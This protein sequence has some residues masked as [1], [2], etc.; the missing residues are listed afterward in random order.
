[1]NRIEA[2]YVAPW[3]IVQ[4]CGLAEMKILTVTC[5]ALFGTIIGFA[6]AGF[7]SAAV[8]SAVFGDR[9]GSSSMSGFF[10][11]GPA[12]ALAGALLGA[13]L[14]LRFGGGASQTWG[15]RL[16]VG[17]CL[18]TVL[19]GIVLAIA[20]TPRRGPSYSQ[21]IEFELEYPSAALAGIDIP[22]ANAM[23]GAA[24]ADADDHP[25]SRFF[26]KKC[27]A[28]TCILNGSVAAL[29]PT[30]NFR[31]TTAIGQN[32]STYPLDLPPVITGPLDWSAWNSGN[33]ARVRWRIVNH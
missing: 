15:Q 8:L 10:G 5:A 3:Y 20:G 30:N 7:G 32:K 24:G 18:L 4:E 16:I 28:D 26:D 14:A 1:M 2:P 12:G 21:V 17:G 11:F 22:S 29:G 23:W 6:A 9:E 33:G 25:I 19:A 27:G 31:I 13:G